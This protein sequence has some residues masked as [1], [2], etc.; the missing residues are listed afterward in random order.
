MG[1]R[2]KTPVGFAFIH[3]NPAKPFNDAKLARFI[4]SH[5]SSVQHSRRRAVGPS[6]LSRVQSID[7]RTESELTFDCHAADHQPVRRYF[8]RTNEADDRPEMITAAA[9]A[10]SLGPQQHD[11]HMSP[12]TAIAINGAPLFSARAALPDSTDECYHLLYPLGLSPRDCIN[13]QVEMSELLLEDRDSEDM[14]STET[15]LMANLQ[16]TVISTRSEMLSLTFLW[17]I[18]TSTHERYVLR[19]IT[20]YFPLQLVKNMQ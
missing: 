8:P 18:K 3:S 2:R 12:G 10:L 17:A 20:E 19:R 7:G 9:R 15:I 11:K 1:K 14:V 4:R 13:R 5:V 6:P 16:K